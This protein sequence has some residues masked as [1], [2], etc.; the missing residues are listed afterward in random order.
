[1]KRG[2]VVYQTVNCWRGRNVSQ[3][4]FYIDVQFLQSLEHNRPLMYVCCQNECV[5]EL[6]YSTLYGSNNR[7]ISVGTRYL[8]KLFRRGTSV[9]MQ[10]VALLFYLRT[11]KKWYVIIRRQREICL[12]MFFKKCKIKQTIQC[13]I[14]NNNNQQVLSVYEV[15]LL[16]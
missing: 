13:Y 1:M 14:H 16:D 5:A 10:V 2:D 6:P 3:S 15:V 9:L 8:G 12:T 7:H 4:F 11:F